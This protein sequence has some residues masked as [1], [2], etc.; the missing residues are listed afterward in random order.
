M[1]KFANDAMESHK[2]GGTNFG[3]SATKIGNLGASEYTLATVVVDVSGS[4]EPYYKDVETVLKEVIASLRKS[5]RADNLMVRVVLFDT[6]VTE[7]HGFRPLP[8]CNEADYDGCIHPGDLTALF[9]ASFSAVEATAQYA[10]ALS[11]NDFQSNAVVFI[12]SDGMDNRSKFPATKVRDAIK[13]ARTS[14]VLESIKPILI[15]VNTDATTGLSQYLD[16]FK[17]EAGIDQYVEIKKADQKTLAKLSGFIS[18]SV[19]STSQ[20]L[21]SGGPSKNIDPSF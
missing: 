20:A 11:K 4:M 6:Q 19:S 12:I 1:G 13:K 16:T 10:E 18:K 2:I 7:M 21:G 15:G 8:D 9:D 5:P 17:T 3:F 14:E